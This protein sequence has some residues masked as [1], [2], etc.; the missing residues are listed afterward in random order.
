M[1][2]H[3]DKYKKV[4]EVGE[5]YPIHYADRFEGNA[6]VLEILSSNDPPYMKKMCLACLD[7]IFVTKKRCRVKFIDG[8]N[9]GWT[10]ARKI[11]N[12]TGS[13]KTFNLEE[14]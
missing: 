3:C 5:S 1:C 14:E 6:E 9:E 10:T 11:E 12:Y 8:I 13:S 7:Y 4:V 2:K